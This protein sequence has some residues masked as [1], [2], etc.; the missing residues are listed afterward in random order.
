MREERR[1]RRDLQKRGKSGEGSERDV[2]IFTQRQ[3]LTLCAQLID[4]E[5]GSSE[6]LGNEELRR[7]CVEFKEREKDK[8]NKRGRN[9]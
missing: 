6:F 3:K 2:C 9:L 4:C 8:E 7:E 5:G 1:L